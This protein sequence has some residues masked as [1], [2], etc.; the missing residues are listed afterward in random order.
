MTKNDEYKINSMNPLYAI[1]GEID[2]FTVD[3]EGSKYLYCPHR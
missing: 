1:V 2:G 3:K